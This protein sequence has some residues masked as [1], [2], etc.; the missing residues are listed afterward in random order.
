MPHP[1]QSP[2]PPGS[3]HSPRPPSYETEA[4]RLRQFGV[5]IEAI[6]KRTQAE[7][8]EHDLRYI[9]RVDRLSR[10]AEL[11]GRTLIAVSP[12]PILFTT[13]VLS[14]WVYKQLQATEIGH[15]ALHGAYNRIPGAGKFHSSKHEWQIPI[16]EQ[17]W[18]RGHNGRHHGLTNVA[19][20]DADIHFGPVRLTE[21]TPHRFSHYFQL[22]FTLLILFPNF[23]FLMNLHFTGLTDVW[24][25]NGRASEFDF[26][27]DRSPATVRD[28]YH[29]ALRKY[30]PYYA[31]EYLMW[32]TLALLT[33]GWWLGPMVFVKSL[34]GNWLA[35]K[36]RDVYSAASIYCG[37][38]GEHTKA[39]PEGTL[40]AGKGERY[41]MQVEATN[42]YEVPWLV[43]VFCGALDRQIEHH[44]FP[45]LPPNRLREIAPE[46]RAACEAHGVNYSTTSWPRMLARAF[47]Q[48]AR[49]SRKLPHERATQAPSPVLAGVSRS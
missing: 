18:L 27:E 47:V 29:R 37:H 40:P 46:V 49:L 7:V 32:P 2:N 3:V 36:M 39:Y 38:V 8:G 12:G 42:N 25:G 9:R 23:G 28:V 16:D 30:V 24:Q 31:K 5:A 13:G 15:M 26:I 45:S 14:L 21:H 20:H 22:P 35:E 17:S 34:F 6:R 11:F 33:F 44:L 19:G 43:S 4:E 10:V 1:A 48:V 41:A